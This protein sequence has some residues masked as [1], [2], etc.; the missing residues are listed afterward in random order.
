MPKNCLSSYE[1]LASKLFYCLNKIYYLFRD[2]FDNIV[3]DSLLISFLNYFIICM[4]YS[5]QG[6]KNDN[7]DRLPILICIISTILI[8]LYAVM[9]FIGNWR[10]PITYYVILLIVILYNLSIVI[11]SKKISKVIGLSSVVILFS[12]VLLAIFG[13]VF[14]YLFNHV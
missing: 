5:N 1:I 11:K 6:R 10:G 4:K 2:Y 3:L 14:L 13:C 8:I 9:Q 7:E 12:V